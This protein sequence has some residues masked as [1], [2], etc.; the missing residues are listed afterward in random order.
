MALGAQ[1]ANLVFV[2]ILRLK[3]KKFYPVYYRAAP[4]EGMERDAWRFLPGTMQGDGHRDIKDAMAAALVLG[5]D[6]NSIRHEQVGYISCPA[7]NII[8]DAVIDVPWIPQMLVLPP[9]GGGRKSLREH[10]ED[11]ARK[12]VRGPVGSLI[13]SPRES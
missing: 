6:L 11:G 4:I 3:N 5:K 8:L 10:L 12:V 13:I 7:E 1:P 2:L 9:F